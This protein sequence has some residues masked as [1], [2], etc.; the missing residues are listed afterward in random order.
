[1]N[2]PQA[3]EALGADV[4]HRDAS[5]RAPL[6]QLHRDGGRGPASTQAQDLAARMRGVEVLEG[7]TGRSG[8]G[9][10]CGQRAIAVRQRRRLAEQLGLRIDRVEQVAA[11]LEKV[12]LVRGD[13]GAARVLVVLD[14]Q[15]DLSVSLARRVQRQVAAHEAHVAHPELAR[16]GPKQTRRGGSAGGDADE[17]EGLRRQ[18]RPCRPVYAAASRTMIAPYSTCL[19]ASGTSSSVKR[20]FRTV[21]IS[22]PTMVPE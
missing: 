13:E 9:G 14:A 20:L 2:G 17:R 8:I 12:D 11:R 16:P 3:I 7:A 4:D 6:Q 19:N 1:M 10:E 5:H 22:A 18:S 15:D 21:R